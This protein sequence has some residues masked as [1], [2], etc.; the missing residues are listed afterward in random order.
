MVSTT[1][2]AMGRVSEL[3]SFD[4]VDDEDDEEALNEQ[5]KVRLQFYVCLYT[6]TYL[7]VVAVR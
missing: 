3:K 6:I 5:H 7:S 2:V 4:K 1:H